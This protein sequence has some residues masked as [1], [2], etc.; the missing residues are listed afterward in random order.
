MA[1]KVK[2]AA[3]QARRACVEEE[4][5][6]AEWQRVLEALPAEDA[7]ILR[8]LLLASS[9]YPFELNARLDD[10]IVEQVG[11]GDASIFETLGARSAQ[12]NLTGP[13]RAFLGGKDPQ[14]FLAMT[15]RIYG[16]YYD[17]GH[18]EYEPTGPTS[19]VI[20]TYDAETFSETDCMTVVG[21][22][23]RALEMCGATSI[24]IEHEECRARGGEVCRY[25]LAW[26]AA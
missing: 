13:H 10:A 19:G 8:G 5:G 18:R 1:A 12:Q 25:R 2:G 6:A 24:R 23:R 11:R 4:Y 14:R 22:Y 16:F 7:D 21:W 9:W 20:T 15:D 26:D 17:S 3:L